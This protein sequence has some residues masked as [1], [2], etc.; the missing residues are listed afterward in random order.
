MRLTFFIALVGS[1]FLGFSSASE[2]RIIK[3]VYSEPLMAVEYNTATRALRIFRGT[4]TKPD[5]MMRMRVRL[6]DRSRLEVFNAKLG[7]EQRLTL[8][9]RG[10]DGASD[11]VYPYSS[12]WNESGVDVHGGCEAR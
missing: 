1:I 12:I 5:Q 10:S 8:D 6:F 7:V 4:A 11:K 3:C 9:H 2:A